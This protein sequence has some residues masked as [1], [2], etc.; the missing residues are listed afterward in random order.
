MKHNTPLPLPCPSLTSSNKALTATPKTLNTPKYIL[1]N[2]A[3]PSLSTKLF[4]PT[5]TAPSASLTHT[6][7][8]PSTSSDLTLSLSPAERRSNTF[9]ILR[10]PTIGVEPAGAEG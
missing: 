6:T 10:S 9:L 1:T 5:A 2:P 7:S 3:S 8:T 4:N